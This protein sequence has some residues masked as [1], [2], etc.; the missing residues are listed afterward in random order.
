ML[1][2][3]QFVLFVFLLMPKKNGGK[4]PL[5]YQSFVKLAGEP[6]SPLTTV[7]SSLPPL[8]HLGGCDVS[9]VPTITD[10]GY[11]DVEQVCV[12]VCFICQII[13]ILSTQ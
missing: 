1:T 6:P 3:D 5:S 7:Y 2:C 4:P 12:S 11:G 9:E 8:G 13:P 10:L